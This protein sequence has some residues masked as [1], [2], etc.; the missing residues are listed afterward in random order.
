M[1]NNGSRYV[2]LDIE[3]YYPYPGTGLSENLPQPETFDPATLRRRQKRKEAHP[4]AK[5]P[6][7]CARRFLTL[8]ARG[9]IRTHDMFEGEIP[10][11]F[12]ELL[13]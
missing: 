8:N 7:R 13:L 3:T 1:Q 5:D 6:R 10:Q 11:D 12:R 2:Y 9:V 4:W